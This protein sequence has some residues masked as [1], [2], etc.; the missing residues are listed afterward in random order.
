MALQ[1]ARRTGGGFL[2]LRELAADGPVLAVFRVRSF[3]PGEK[4]DFGNVNLP[5]IADVLIASGPRAGEVHAGERFI[6]AVT[7]TLRGVR[8]P[9]PG[10]QPEP[11][12]T[13]VGDEIVGRIKV[14]NQGKGNAFAG[15]DEPS[16]AEMAAVELV[17][18]DGKGWDNAPAPASAPEPAS[19]GA[20]KSRP[21]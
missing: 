8:N 17:Y 10:E 4:N 6:G 15:I 19:A 5:V 7:S 21:W 9:K 12:A 13:S 3:E 2:D 16:D 14:V 20:G 11:P 18:A 1:R